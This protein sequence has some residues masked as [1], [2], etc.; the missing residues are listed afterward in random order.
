VTIVMGMIPLSSRIS[1]EATALASNLPNALKGDPLA[2]LPI[3]RWLEPWRPQI[4]DYLH[5]RLLD[6]G[7][8]AGPMLSAASGHI[9]TGISA[10]L[11]AVLIPII[12]FFFLKDGAVIR[13]AIVETF[14][15]SQ[16]PLIN[17]LLLDLHLLLAQY[18]RALVLL[19][20]ATFVSYSIFLAA[21]GIAFP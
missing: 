2:N 5:A 11:T 3:P 6:L 12:G 14:R 13:A 4:T 1:D 16:Q 17:S 8:T 21:A 20:L 10:A 19:S 15:R 18:I 9:L 7:R